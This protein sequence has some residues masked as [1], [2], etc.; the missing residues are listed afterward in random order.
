MKYTRLFLLIVLGL[1]VSQASYAQR[2]ISSLQEFID[3]QGASNQ[4]IRM[5]PGTYHISSLSKSLF[6]GGDW[7]VNEEGNW[8]GIFNFTGSNNTF[9]LSGVTIT[10]DST[11][12]NEMRNLAHGNLILLGGRNNKWTGLNVQELPDNIGRY[13]VYSHVSGGTVMQITGRDHEFK[14]LTVK[15]RFSH[16]YGFGSLYGKTGSSAGSLPGSRLGKKS[17]LRLTELTD[18]TF[19]NVLVD[20]SAFGHTLFFNGPI[21]DVV[22]E[23]VTVIAETRSTND[24]R[25]NGLQGTD[26]NGVPFGLN[27]DRQVLFG[28][29]DNRD[30]FD[31]FDTNNL[32]RCQSLGSGFQRGPIRENY[33]YSLTEGAFRGYTQEEIEGLILRNV[34]VVGARSGI[35]MD[36]AGRGLEVENM[37]VLGV[38]GHGVPSCNGAWNSDN[39]GEGDA[40]AFGLPSFAVVKAARADAAYAT[41]IEAG[42]D[43]RNIT[44]DIEV[45]DPEN[46]YLRPSGSTA[47]ALISGRDHDI[48]LWK[49]DG[50]R[51][52]QDLV[53]KVGNGSTS[54]LLLCNMTEQ[55]VT[56]SRN[57]TNSTIYSMGNVIDSSNGSNTIVN[58]AN[59][60]QEPS[61]CRA[62]RTTTPET[63]PTT[64]TTPEVTPPTNNPSSARLV[65][66]RKRNAQGFAI[67][68]GRGGANGQSVYIWAQNSNNVNQQWVEIDRGNGY[69]SYQ[70]QGTNFCIDG[71]HGGADRQDVYLWQCVANNQ[72][73]HWQKSSTGSGFF[74]LIKR[75]APGFT[76]D[77][78][79]NGSNG[80]NVNLY[81]S[82]R[83]SHNLQWSIT[84]ID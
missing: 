84:P 55:A 51:L 63:T 53:I 48:R 7:R 73:Q 25:A 21:D 8:P 29:S 31:F 70:K 34:T 79:S 15:S 77:G 43:R 67:D 24:L 28:A 82:S 39:G 37:T 2:T 17:G 47:L 71:N 23:N 76:I 62:L 11:I 10:F 54:G 13:G 75:N 80:Q 68:G 1:F 50:R 59:L 83:S 19:D 22:M 40:T 66:I 14:D 78:G 9:D 64:P 69:Y 3:L 41:V 60:N 30:F 26:R 38:A 4:N 56:L 5:L 74:K 52:A 57:V 45:L 6:D 49:R 12:I 33:Q 42:D 81:D 20:H 32:D 58:V 35:A 44:A 46:G 65:H 18:S 36:V 27:Y 16:P 61:A 72:N